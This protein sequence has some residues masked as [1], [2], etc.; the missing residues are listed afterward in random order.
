MRC[1]Q[2]SKLGSDAISTSPKGSAFGHKP[3]VYLSSLGSEYYS[4]VHCSILLCAQN[5]DSEVS[6]E[7]IYHRRSHFGNRII[8]EH[9]E[10]FGE[11]YWIP[12][13]CLNKPLASRLDKCNPRLWSSFFV[14]GGRL[15]DRT[16]YA[17]WQIWEC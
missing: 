7:K 13:R 4:C 16:D 9:Y 11:I 3:P 17:E 5:V 6:K 10:L 2:R 14:I 8:S 15:A 1:L 12:P